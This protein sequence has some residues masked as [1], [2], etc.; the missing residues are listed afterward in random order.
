MT[1]RDTGSLPVQ[2][3]L[4]LFVAMQMVFH[5]FIPR[6]VCSLHGHVTQCLEEFGAGLQKG[7]WLQT[8][9]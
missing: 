7:L 4:H 9:G 5:M 1:E 6:Q 2:V 8:S 3:P